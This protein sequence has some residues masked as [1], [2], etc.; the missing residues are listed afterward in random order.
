VTQTEADPEVQWSTQLDRLDEVRRDAVVAALRRSAS[1]G[2]PASG[3]A[4]ELLVAYALGEISSNGYA[5][6]ILRSWG[7]PPPGGEAEPDPVPARP[8]PDP[9][10]DVEPAPEAPPA[11]TRREEAVHAYVTG[12]IDVGEFLRI[13]RS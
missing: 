13:A 5:L 12:R 9:Q 6:G 4:V 8:E 2:W 7:V 11:R 3:D 10:L 1:I